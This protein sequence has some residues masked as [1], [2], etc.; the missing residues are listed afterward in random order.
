MAAK[1]HR[2]TQRRKAVG[3]TQERLAERLGVDSKTV[4]RWESGETEDGP[5]PW[6]RP[7]LADCLQVSV[8]QLG[9]LLQESMTDD[10]SE[11]RTGQAGIPAVPTLPLQTPLA[12]RRPN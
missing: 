1:R 11:I 12:R 3:F 10:S 2:L 4:R 5:Q 9:E 7:K 8:E 6:L